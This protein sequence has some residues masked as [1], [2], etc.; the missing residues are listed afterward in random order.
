MRLSVVLA[1]FH[2]TVA[3][4]S[5]AAPKSVRF[6]AVNPRSTRDAVSR[7]VFRAV[8]LLAPVTGFTAAAKAGFFES[9]EQSLVNGIAK[10]QAPVA[11]LL[12]QLRPTELPN[13]I[14]V[15]SKQQLL[16]GGPEDSAVVLN[17]L[18]TYIKP[19]QIKMADA[20]PQLKLDEE[21]QKRLELLPALMKG[22]ILE[23]QQAINEQKAESQAR[24][25]EEVQETLAEFLLLASKKYEVTPYKPSRPLS[26]KVGALCI[27]VYNFR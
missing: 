2:V 14:G 1:A 21:S 24:E 16:R 4:K 9:S 18:E 6:L 22:H 17:Y 11:E 26:D 10:Y 15:Y 3:F 27:S 7:D 25:V 13:S 23:L 12:D 20:A 19:C 8:L 5:S